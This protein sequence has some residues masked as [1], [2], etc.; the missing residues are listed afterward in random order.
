MLLSFKAEVRGPRSPRVPVHRTTGP[1]DKLRYCAKFDSGIKYAN[2]KQRSAF[3]LVKNA[4]IEKWI[5][6]PYAHS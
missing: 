6:T 2:V 1:Y 4:S 3:R 5:P